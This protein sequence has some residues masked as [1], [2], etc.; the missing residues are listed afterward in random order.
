M[1]FKWRMMFRMS[2]F[3]SRQCVVVEGLLVVVIAAVVVGVVVVVCFIGKRLVAKANF[4][5][6]SFKNG[7]V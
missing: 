3:R 4:F 1:R 7:N 2:S 5:V 6:G